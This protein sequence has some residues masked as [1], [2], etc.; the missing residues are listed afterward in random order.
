MPHVL[1]IYFYSM[2]HI[3]L[4]HA[5][6]TP[7]ITPVIEEMTRVMS[8]HY[9]NASSIHYHGRQAKTIV[10]Q[11]RKTVALEL[12]ASL[13]EIFFCSTATEAHNMILFQSVN[14]LGVKRIISSPLEHHCILHTLEHISEHSDTE[15][16][17]LNVDHQ[18]QLDYDQLATLLNEEPKT[19]VSLMYVNNELGNINNIQLVSDLCQEHNALFHC[20]TVQGI[21]KLKIDLNE[22]PMAFAAGSAHKFNGPKGVGFFYMNSEN[23][24][25]PMILGGAQERNMR[26]GT[27]NVYGISGLATAL[28]YAANERAERAAHIKALNQYFRQKLDEVLVDIKINGTNQIDNILSVSFPPSEKAD[29]LMFNLDISG[30]SA[31]SGSAC[32]SGIALDSHV[33]TAI[34]HPTDRKTIRFSFSHL[35]TMEEIDYVIEKLTAFTPTK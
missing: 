26:A 6:T 3:Y 10:E 20:D 11:A 12:S 35:N 23:I 7:L 5:A 8:D 30:I 25:P 16:I 2:K 28:S 4:D 32:S 34:N 14:H 1:L 15:V 21:G 9:G 19:L 13:G 24:I 22:T 17:Y 31:S 27:E 18:G 33:L 29:L